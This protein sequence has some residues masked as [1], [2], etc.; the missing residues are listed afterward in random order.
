MIV[1]SKFSV[2]VKS[3]NG[4]YNIADVSLFDT[5]A[6]C[7]GLIYPVVRI[8]DRKNIMFNVRCPFC[9]KYHFYSCKIND[10]FKKDMIIVGCSSVGMP[11]LYAGKSSK[12][13]QKI[14]KYQEI[15]DKVQNLI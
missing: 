10:F 4:K 2:A 1:N 7:F 9:G 13:K 6:Q 15:R 11:V 14:R 3:F 12:V 8:Y 5:S